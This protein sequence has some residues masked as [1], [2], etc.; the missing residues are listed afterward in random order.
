MAIITISRG[1]FSHGKEIAETVA[2]RLEYECISKEILLEASRTFDIPE[3]KLSSSVHDAPN[4]LERFTH[5]RQRFLNCI[6]AALLEHVKKDNVVFHGHAGHLFLPGIAHVLKIR[7]IAEMSDRIALV[8]KTRGLAVQEAEALIE[9]EDRQRDEWYRTIYKRDIGDATLYD[10]LIHIGNLTI[11]D[12]CDL[13]C[14][15]AGRES[16][17]ATPESRAALENLTLASQVEAALADIGGAEITAADGVVRVR[18]KGKKL[19]V[20]GYTRPGMQQRVT[21]RI[22]EDLHQEITTRVAKI[23]GVKDLIFDIDPPYYT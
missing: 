6:R 15:A 19:K 3:K 11:D 2:K 23:P 20:T 7:I 13:I 21:Q 18:A 14:T 10:L 4:L 5:A 17:R 22:Q 9:A 16:F 1:C 8:Q 12:A